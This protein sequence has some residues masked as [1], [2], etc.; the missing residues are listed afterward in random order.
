MCSK[1]IILRLNFLNLWNKT[2]NGKIVLNELKMF[3]NDYKLLWIFRFFFLQVFKEPER[4]IIFHANLITIAIQFHLREKGVEKTIFFAR[5]LIVQFGF[6]RLQIIFLKIS[7]DSLRV[8]IPY[9]LECFLQFVVNSI[10]H[11]E[12]AKPRRDGEHIRN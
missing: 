11:W 10:E 7:F 4:G 5:F 3:L 8:K 1:P 9:I 12:M 6:F 2:D